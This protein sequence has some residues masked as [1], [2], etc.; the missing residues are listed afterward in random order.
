[1]ISCREIPSPD[2]GVFALSPIRLP[3]PGLVA[4]DTMRDSLGVVAPLEVLAYGLDGEP[5]SPQ[6]AATF[7]VLD[8]VAHTA[9]VLLIGEEPGTARVV[10]AVG[11][12]QTQPATVKVTLSPDVLVAG[13]SVLHHKSYSIL[14]GDTVIVSA[15]LNVLVQHLGTPNSGV[16]AVIVRYS[17]EQAPTSNGSGPTV[18]LFSENAASSRDTTDG[19]GRAARRARLRLAALATVAEDTVRISATSSYRGQSI[20][21][22]QFTVIYAKQ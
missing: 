1:M 18:V 4:G 2:D 15:D 20:G 5:L 9:G 10:G 14:S 13:D 16:E 11:A 8:T 12:L 19:N 6:P 7:I 22:V 21:S 3:L 17:I